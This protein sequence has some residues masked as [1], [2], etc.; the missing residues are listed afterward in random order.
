MNT[1]KI[2]IEEVRTMLTIETTTHKLT[3]VYKAKTSYVR[4]KAYSAE[5]VK[6]TGANG[7]GVIVFEHDAETGRAYFFDR[8][9]YLDAS[10]P[11]SESQAL[12]TYL[13]ALALFAS[14]GHK[15]Y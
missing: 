11:M 4:G 8:M 3:G 2:T 12:V 10:D 13:S 5:I 14:Q 6:I 9:S 1:T 15:I 7:Y